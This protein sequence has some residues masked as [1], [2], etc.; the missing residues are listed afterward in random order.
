MNKHKNMRSLFRICQNNK[1]LFVTVNPKNPW[2]LE[3]TDHL[4]IP[5]IDQLQSDVV[6]FEIFSFQ[7]YKLVTEWKHGTSTSDII[8]F[9][10]K[11]ENVSTSLIE[12][13]KIYAYS[14][15]GALVVLN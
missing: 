10:E 9:N 14:Y 1:K 3:F 13:I 11:L 6:V 15:D 4:W 7:I 12:L 2:K 8:T 5:F